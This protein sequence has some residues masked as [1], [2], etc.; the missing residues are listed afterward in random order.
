MVVPSPDWFTGFY[1]LRPI[2]V[3][4]MWLK[5]F[6][7]DTYP[8]DSGTDSGVTYKSANVATNPQDSIFQITAE[9]SP[10]ESQVFVNTNAGVEPVARWTFTLQE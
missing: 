3:D 7:I 10:A 1:N 4:G 8:W 9:T 5:E 6:M 2:T